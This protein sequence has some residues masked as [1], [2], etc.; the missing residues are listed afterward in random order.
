MPTADDVKRAVLDLAKNYP[1]AR[2]EPCQSPAGNLCLYARGKAGP[3]EG[4]IIG[5]A[6]RMVGINPETFDKGESIPRANTL[7]ISLFGGTVKNYDWNWFLRVQAHQ[8]NGHTWK[9]SIEVN[10]EI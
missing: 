1:D 4:C 10:A 9:E 5:Q 8:D 6:L 3:G 2:Y 7:M